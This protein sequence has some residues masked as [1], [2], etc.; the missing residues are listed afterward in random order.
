MGVFHHASPWTERQLSI[1]LENKVLYFFNNPL[2]KDRRYYGLFCI[3]H[4]MSSMLL[5]CNLINYSHK[6]RA[7][8][9]TLQRRKTC[10]FPLSISAFFAG[11]FTN[12]LQTNKNCYNNSVV[13]ET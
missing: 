10:C 12:I 8:N 3:G 6:N 9:F 2:Q 5:I 4:D 1:G 7:Q 13:L 11:N